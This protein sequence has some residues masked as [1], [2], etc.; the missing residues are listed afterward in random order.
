VVIYVADARIPFACLNP[1]LIR[2]IGAKPILYLLSKA[3]LAAPDVSAEWERYFTGPA[4]QGL[5]I[6]A[7]SSKF[8]NK[9]IAAV[10]ALAADKINR[11]REKGV[12]YTP[13][14]IVIGIPNTGKSTVINSLAGAKRAQ[15]GDKPGVTRGKQWVK[16]DGKIEL[17]D[18]PGAL[19]A[20][21]DSQRLARHVAYVGS[22][23]D[24]I[25]DSAFLAGELLGE[26]A[27]IAPGC[28][29]SRYGFSPSGDIT[30][31]L[32][33]LARNRGFLRGG[34]VADT[35]R[36]AAA[37]IEDFRKGRLGRVSIERPGED[38]A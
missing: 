23:N 9:I 15:T 19:P 31:D 5:A 27:V 12:N 3:D 10:T 16:I 28:I 18:M 6:C 7:V 32:E 4:A 21:F 35:D 13:K 29:S 2:A 17:L 36:A 38:Y 20:K 25:I 11:R 22:I 1:A 8:N 34:G 30:A 26:L 14:T 33:S 24:D 37:L